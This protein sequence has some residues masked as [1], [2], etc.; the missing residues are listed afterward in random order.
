MYVIER[1]MPQRRGRFNQ[2]LARTA[3]TG[4]GVGDDLARLQAP[5]LAWL[6][7]NAPGG[8][9]S[10]HSAK[11]SA[12][13]R[14]A[15]YGPA[16]RSPLTALSTPPCRQGEAKANVLATFSRFERR[17]I[18]QRRPRPAAAALAELVN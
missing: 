8:R 18:S 5:L 2:F 6:E 14:A 4:Q 16:L 3:L 7:P 15:P 9:F 1:T 17:L 13:T 12:S 11:R 10:A